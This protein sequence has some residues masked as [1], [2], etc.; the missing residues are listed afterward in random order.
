LSHSPLQFD[1]QSSTP[2]A[3]EVVLAMEPFWKEFWGNPSSRNNRL[4]LKASAAV[5][6]AREEIASLLGI[7]SERIVFTSGATESNN[8]ALLG[9]ARARAQELGRPGNIITL[10]TEHHAVLD[11]LRQLQVEGFSLTEISP[12]PDGIISIEKLVNAL[13]IDTFLVSIMLANNEIGVIQPIKEISRVCKEYGVIFHTDAAQ[14]IGYFPLNLKNYNLDLV[15]ISGH[16][17]YGPKGIGGLI[18]KSE[19]SLHPLQWGGGQEDALRPGTLPVPLVVGFAKAI[20]IAYRDFNSNN[21]K[22]QTLRNQLWKGLKDR[23]PDLILNGSFEKRLPHNLNF[24]VP[25]VRGTRMHAE[26][27]S[28]IACSSG[29]ACSQGAPSHVLLALGRTKSQAAA[30]F[31]LSLSRETSA[32]DV[33]KVISIFESSISNMRDNDYD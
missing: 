13:K 18:A 20:Q 9:Y 27:R 10:S 33:K 15:S 1:F 12:E 11:P 17:V 25:G 24:T 3:E 8:L 4:G 29:S 2:C 6:L 31:R 28:L 16:K 23:F 21:I 26:L 7:T 19:L 14:A 32:E 30:S 5:M 22:L